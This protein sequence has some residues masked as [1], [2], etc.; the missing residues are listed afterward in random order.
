MPATPEKYHIS[1][2]REEAVRFLA[3]APGMVI[4]DGTLGGGGHSEAFL[5]AGADVIASDLDP[6]ARVFDPMFSA[7]LVSPQ[8]SDDLL[9]RGF[10]M[11]DDILNAPVSVGSHDFVKPAL[12]MSLFGVHRAGST[13]GSRAA[14]SRFAMS[15]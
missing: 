2:L 12:E 1:V 9:V 15:C 13:G 3:P 14:V 10:E 8:R 6:D 11:P 7:I 5:E 4:F